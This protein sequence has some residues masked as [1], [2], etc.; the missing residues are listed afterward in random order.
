MWWDPA[1][2]SNDGRDQAH[3]RDPAGTQRGVARAVLAGL[4]CSAGACALYETS[5]YHRIEPYGVWKD[6][7]QSICYEKY[8]VA[9]L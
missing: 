2:R 5:G 8:L 7:P 3:V 6:S 1:H 4:D 9:Y